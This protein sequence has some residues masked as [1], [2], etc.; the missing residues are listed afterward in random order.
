MVKEDA[1]EQTVD[2]LVIGGGAAG[3]AA[4]LIASLEGLRVA[5]VEKTNQ[6]GGTMSTS[7]GTV[8][9]PGNQQSLDAGY[10]DSIDKARTYL[11][12]LIQQEDSQGLR[13][14]YLQTAPKMIEYLRKKTD[15]QF[16]PSGKHPDYQDKE[17]AAVVGR[18]LAPAVFDGRLLG[19]EFE[20]VRPPIPEFMVLG[21]MMAGKADIPR[22]V[23]RFGSIADFFYSGKLFLRYVSDRL[24]YSRGTRVVMGNALAARLFYSLRKQGVPILFE[25]QVEALIKDNQ[26]VV[27]ADLVSQGKKI[28][29]HASKGVLIATGGYGHNPE[30]RALCMPTPTPPYSLACASNTGD[31]IQLGLK[32]SGVIRPETQGCG[33]FWTPVSVVPRAD[34]S[35]GLYPHLSLDRA[36]P[37][38][39]AVNRAGQRFVNE[40][41]SYHDFVEG[42]YQANQTASSIPAFLICE[43][44][45]VK[46]YGLG[47]IYPGTTNLSKA[48]KAGY[49]VEA[50]TV[51]QLAQQLH[52]PSATLEATL[53]HYNELVER[54]RDTDFG[55]GESELNVFNGDP[56]SKPNACLGPIK[57]GP[58]VALT[59]WPAEIGT[60]TGLEADAD[61]RVLNEDGQPIDGLYV[62]GNDMASIMKGTYPGPGTTL[63]PALTFAYR[64]VMHAVQKTVPITKP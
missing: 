30:L 26:K 60:S 36:K 27:G 61:A 41:D 62:A 50:E 51:E 17:G 48:V 19:K 38:L 44:Q 47:A 14:A 25:T 4:A 10:D 21:G 58:F 54:G 9:I 3:M 18:T 53:K 57:Q 13:E 24:K 16:V 20:R 7:A 5:L 22:L 56:L 12:G 59:I 28:R 6:V 55:K 49:V 42:M 45:F 11:D 46:T 63:G 64:A 23:N 37:G 52:I 34:G 29:V 39:I 2:F 43:K 31:G 33:A 8:W 1:C 32:N 35:K 40:A 15:V